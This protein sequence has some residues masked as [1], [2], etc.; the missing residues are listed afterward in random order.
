[1]EDQ[2][3][4]FLSDRNRVSRAIQAIH[5]H[6]EMN[7]YTVE[8]MKYPRE[9]TSLH[10]A[11]YFGLQHISTCLLEQG[12]DPSAKN[13]LATTPLHE[14]A[15]RGHRDIV[16]V[17]LSKGADVDFKDVKVHTPL[18]QASQSAHEDVVVIFL[19]KKAS[20]SRAV[21]GRTALHFATEFGNEVIVKGVIGNG[22]DVMSKLMRSVTMST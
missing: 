5:F 15:R 11:A 6:R 2:I 17:L 12:A 1:M 9:V 3:L 20:I 19:I 13:S 21:D 10:I 14:A 16:T 4:D 7:W 22:A 8:S 18:H